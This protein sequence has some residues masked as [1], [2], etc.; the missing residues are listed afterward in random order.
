M[1]EDLV[2]LNIRPGNPDFTDL[3][4]EKHL[5]VWSEF[6][7]RLEQVQ[8]GVSRHPVVFVNYDGELFAV[9]ELSGGSAKHEY[10]MLC[11]VEEMR[12][13]SVV[14]VGYANIADPIGQHSA[15]ITHFLDRSLPYRLLIVRSG[16]Q[17]YEQHLLDAMANL[18]VQLHLSGVFWGDCSL[19]NTLFRRDAGA[20]QAYM[21]DA[22]T[23]EIHP[24]RLAPTLRFHD[25][26]IMEENIRGEILDLISEGQLHP[27]TFG[28]VS[29]RDTGR[30]VR[31]R[32]NSL[33]DE[34]TREQLITPGEHYRIQ[35]RIRLLNNMGYSVR[36]VEIL[37]S[38]KG[39]NLRLRV[40]VADRNLH[41]DQLMNLTGLEVEEGQATKMMN[42]IIELQGYFSS[43]N[44]RSMPLSAAATYWLEQIYL[45]TIDA[46]R[47]LIQHTRDSGE[48][49]DETELYLQVLEHKW[50]L[51]EQ[52]N[53]DV[54]HQAAAED[55]LKHFDD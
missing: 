54:G 40:M 53:R 34:I 7:D 29:F 28:G 22:E 42:E 50:Y 37:P 47:P 4:W 27:G 19:S 16:L 11:A 55:F 36:Q 18:L 31:Q 2:S 24:P 51:S 32:Y 10:D 35:E 52:A 9:K 44:K 21:V 12:L 1:N 23:V 43:V 25:L 13:P 6:S 33:W 41:R 14:P 45:P 39:D 3:P 30:F 38:E 15:L 17:R 26:E 48:L 46:L 8:A 5:P 49:M 20:L